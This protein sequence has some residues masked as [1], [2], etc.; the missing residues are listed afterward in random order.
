MK[1]YRNEIFAVTQK[2]ALNQCKHIERLITIRSQ[3]QAVVNWTIDWKHSTV[4]KDSMVLFQLKI[5]LSILL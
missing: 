2:V 3:S 1:Q 4:P 5:Q